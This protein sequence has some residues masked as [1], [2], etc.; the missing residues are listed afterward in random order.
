MQRGVHVFDKLRR[1]AG[2]RRLF[3][4][5]GGFLSEDRFIRSP[6]GISDRDVDFLDSLWYNMKST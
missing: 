2:A 5:N 4:S 3:D 1:W 6:P